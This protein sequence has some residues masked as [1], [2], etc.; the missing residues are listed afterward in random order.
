MYPSWIARGFARGVVEI[1]VLWV[2]SRSCP[3]AGINPK[4]AANHVR[5]VYGISHWHI[6]SPGSNGS[7]QRNIRGSPTKAGH[8]YH[9]TVG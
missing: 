3:V 6:N 7:Y 8:I 1:A 2:L 4:E 9:S 5:Q